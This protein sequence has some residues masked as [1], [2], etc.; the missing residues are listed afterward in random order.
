MVARQGLWLKSAPKWENLLS[1]STTDVL[2]LV[3]TLPEFVDRCA[4]RLGTDIEQDADVGVD[5]WT[6]SI[7]EPS[8]RVE[9]L[10]VLLLHYIGVINTDELEDGKDLLTTEDDLNWAWGLSNL[11]FSGHSN[12]TGVLENVCLNILSTNSVFSHTILIDTHQCQ[13][14]ERSLID[15]GSSI[16]DDANYDFLPT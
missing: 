14:L 5:K 3:E 13:D 1:T 2:V 11:A 7:E 10:L 16:R 6:E 4:S 8:M 15:L 12:T 9:F